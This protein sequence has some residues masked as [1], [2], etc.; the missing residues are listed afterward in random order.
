M[1]E[2]VS[3]ILAT[4]NRPN[5]VRQALRCFGRQTYDQSELIVIDDGEPPVADL[6]EGL[7][8]IRYVWLDEPT[9]LGNKLNLGVQHARGTIIQKLDDDDYYAPGF[10]ARA[11]ENLPF[12]SRERS[13]VAWDCFLVVIVG[14]PH[15]RHSGHGW[16]AGGTLCFSRELWERAPFR[17]VPCNVDHWFFMDHHPK[18]VRVC[19]PEMYVLVRHG[20]NTWKTM[21]GRLVEEVFRQKPIYSK[22]LDELVEPGDRGFYRS[23]TSGAV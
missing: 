14:E 22:T 12:A 9:S 23:L 5:F 3:C 8:R 21:H 13:I 2:L 18:V 7:P 19:A 6:C 10:L 17:D 20:G 11:V 15:L 4:G 16:A 1:N